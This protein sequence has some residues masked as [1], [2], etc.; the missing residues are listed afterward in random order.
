MISSTDILAD[1]N[2]SKRLPDVALHQPIKLHLGLRNPFQTKLPLAD[3]KLH[4]T[5]TDTS[6]C[7]L[8]VNCTVHKTSID[9]LSREVF[10]FLCVPRKAGTLTIDGWSYT[11]FNR[12]Q[13]WQPLGRR[14]ME[15]KVRYGLPALT[16]YGFELWPDS[17]VEGE[18]FSCLLVLTPFGNTDVNVT[19]SCAQAMFDEETSF[20]A[21]IPSGERTSVP[22]TVCAGKCHLYRLHCGEC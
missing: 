8:E 6:G 21:M 2:A 4:A 18:Y 1:K 5:L 13:C 10:E 9:P 16:Q 17:V 15:W 14:K 3:M 11:L 19:I 20:S 12:V 22:V 7:A